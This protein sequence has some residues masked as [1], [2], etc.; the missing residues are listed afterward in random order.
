MIDEL[1][2]KIIDKYLTEKFLFIIIAK[3]YRIF[4]IK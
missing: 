2:A 1:I 4:L 3:K